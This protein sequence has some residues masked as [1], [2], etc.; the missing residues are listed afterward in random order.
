MVVTIKNISEAPVTYVT[1]SV[2]SMYEING[3]VKRTDDGRNYL[4][5]TTLTY[6]MRPHLPDEPPRTVNPVPLM[7]GNSTDLVLSEIQRNEL[8][9]ILRSES[10]STDLPELTVWI[11]HV[12]W[13]GDEH[14]MW[15]NGRMLRQDPKDPRH[16]EPIATPSSSPSPRR[17]NHAISKLQASLLQSRLICRFAPAFLILCLPA[18]LGMAES[19]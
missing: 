2:A 4:A 17:L 12:A 6:G 7:P 14:R 11:D 18:S 19:R 10:A 9:S 15:S 3:A 1:V 16:W 5:V 13:Y 8:H